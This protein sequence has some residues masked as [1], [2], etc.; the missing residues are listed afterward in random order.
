MLTTAS[1]SRRWAAL[2]AVALLSPLVALGAVAPAQAK[3]G[4]TCDGGGFALVN[5]QTTAVV[6]RGPVQ[7]VVQP[8]ALGEATFGVR[9]RYVSFDVRLSDFAVLDYA[10]TGA[11]SPLDLTGGRRTPVFESKTPDHRGL[12]LSGG[13]SVTLDGDGLALSRAGAG[14]SMKIQAKDCAQGG[15]FQ[16][17]PERA[18]ATAT[19]M[20]HTLANPAD[21]ALAPFYFDNPEFRARIGQFLGAGC[22]SVTTG[23]AGQYCVQVTAR[24]NIGNSLSPNFVARDSAQLAT[25]VPQADCTT[26]TAL[27]SSVRH[28]GGQSIWDVATG[29]RMGFVAGGD[30][31]EVANPPTLCTHQ[32]RGHNQVQGQLVS[33]GAPFP[34]PAGSLLV[35]RTSQAVL[36]AMTS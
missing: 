26:A 21:P 22:T 29:G 34:V 35:P 11:A 20:I 32:C 12:T 5:P 6:A 28:C 24:T 16:M 18:D 8:A 27:P 4:E 36:P 19:R 31:V 15:I 7:Q 30:A 3:G 13:V 2:A 23:P 9:G 14:L 1:R 33:L 10:F 17:E 25:R